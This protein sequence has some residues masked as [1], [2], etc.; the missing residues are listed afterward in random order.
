[1]LQLI[2]KFGLSHALS[3]A[4][5]WCVTHGLTTNTGW[6]TIS[7][8]I[9]SGIAYLVHWYQAH[10]AAQVAG[11]VPVPSV[12][13]SPKAKAAVSLF[14]CLLIPEFLLTGCGGILPKDVAHVMNFTEDGTKV[15]IG[16]N[17]VTQMPELS[18]GREQ[19][20]VTVIPIVFQTNAVSGQIS[21]VVPDVV[22]SYEFNGRNATFGGMS[23]TITVA[24][25]TNAVATILGGGHV[26]INAG[27]GT[28][29]P[30]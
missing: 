11:T 23:G 18:V 10:H 6:Q 7:G 22:M 24:T 3:I 29:L 16:Q 17:A 27:T 8:F 26:P 19:A 20:D 21:A 12:A 13:L 25:G 2:I 4:G 5:V 15:H 28:S 9:I 14:L 30:K 1:M